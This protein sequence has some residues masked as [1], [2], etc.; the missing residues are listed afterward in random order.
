MFRVAERIRVLCF[1]V[2]S[3]LEYIGA[4]GHDPQQFVWVDYGTFAA[5]WPV[6][7]VAEK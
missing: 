4:W 6:Y 7:T 1:F 3:I 5:L 2:P